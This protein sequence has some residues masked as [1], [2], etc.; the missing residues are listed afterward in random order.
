MLVQ[1][2]AAKLTLDARPGDYRL[3]VVAAEASTGRLTAITQ[4][5]R[6]P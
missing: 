1:G 3:R 2:L 5:V 6:I 4:A